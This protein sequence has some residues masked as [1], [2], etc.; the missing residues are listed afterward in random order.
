[1]ATATDLRNEPIRPPVLSGGWPILGHLLEL[2]RDPLALMRRLRNECG[3][4]GE[5]NLAGN[6]IT[7]LTGVE[8]QEAFFRAPDEQ[9]DQAAA[10][11]FMK[12]VFG[13]GVV[14]DATPEQRK[15]AMRNQSLRDKFMR[16]HAETIAAEVERMIAGWGERG[17]I[18]VLD[19]FSELTLYTS[20]ACLIGKQF[21]DELGPDYVPIFKDLERGTDALAYVNPYLPI[22]ALRARDRARRELVAKIEAVFERR[23]RD[24]VEY[25]D[26]FH[27]LH[28]LRDENG[29]RRYDDDQITGMFISMMFAGHHTTSVVSSWAL[30]EMLMHPD[31]MQKTVSE[32]DELYADERDVS[33]QAL[34]EIPL[35]ECALKETLRLHPPLIIL[36]RKVVHD[37]HYGGYT[38]PAG[39][40]VAASPAISNRMPEHFPEPERFAPERYLPGREEDKQVFAWIPFGA[41]RHRC[42]GAAFAMMQLKA[43]FS[44]LLRDFE[45]ELAQPAESYGNDLS[46]MV[47]A[48]RQPCR[49]RYRRRVVAR[50]SVKTAKRAS[51]DAAA[52]GAFRIRVDLDL[53][54]GHAVCMGEA[55]EV[56]EID[57]DENKVILLQETPDPDNREAA[58]LAVRHCPTRALSIEE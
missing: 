9:L 58:R 43:I 28:R 13:E 39:R 21:R 25:T 38:I 3:D 56:F 16:G 15:Q 53:C 37:F 35:L 5:F 4:V 14:F 46:K 57:R 30:L 20:S 55:P 6:R 2:R 8:A 32:L 26:L 41:G 18:D 34:R 51:A 17:E 23:D 42:V 45:F 31:W 29:V 12:P 10:Y 52:E 44:I 36:M 11:P 24:E 49:V 27:V 7:L 33:Y 50:P 54:Q 19:F 40:T 22:P 47:V 1:M 48:V